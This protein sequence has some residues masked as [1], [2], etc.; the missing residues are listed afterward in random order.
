MGGA[1]GDA[2]WIG[3]AALRLG[4]V[5]QAAEAGLASYDGAAIGSERCKRS[6]AQRR[7]DLGGDIPNGTPVSSASPGRLSAVLPA[8]AS[9]L[10]QRHSRL[11]PTTTTARAPA[12]TSRRQFRLLAWFS[13][14]SAART[15]MERRSLR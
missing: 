4:V 12:Y 11:T 9:L 7:P 6:V 3:G 14:S 8:G 1:S 15:P 10:M 2:L 13:G 5:K